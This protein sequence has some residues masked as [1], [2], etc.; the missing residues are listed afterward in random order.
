MLRCRFIIAGCIVPRIPALYFNS[1]GSAGD[2]LIG[3]WEYVGC[4]IGS[5]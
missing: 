3:D 5:K 2:A 1:M 4:K